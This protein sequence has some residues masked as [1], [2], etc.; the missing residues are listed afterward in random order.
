[1]GDNDSTAYQKLVEFLTSLMSMTHIYQP[2]ML[3]TLLEGGGTATGRQIAAA[4]LRSDLSQLAY[5]EKVA[6]RW[7]ART[8]KKHGL[9][10]H[11]RGLYR[12]TS[13]YSGLAEWERL[14]LIALCEQKLA[15]HVASRQ[16]R[17]LSLRRG[18]A[19][20][21]PGSM[22][23]KAL[24]RASSRC[25]ACGVSNEIRALQVDH[26]VPKRVGGSNEISN[27]QVLC[28]QCNA[29]KRDRDATDFRAVKESYSSREAGCPF[30]EVE[31]RRVELDNTLAIVIKDQFPVTVG[32]SLIV[33]RRHTTHFFDL[34][35]PKVNAVWQLL[36][37]AKGGIESSDSS[38]T[39]FNVGV[40]DGSVAGQTVPHCHVHLI[41]RRKNDVPD[42]GGGVR[43]VIPERQK[44]Q[45]ASAPS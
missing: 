3:R 34:Y 30:C 18:V 12:L 27:L 33:P 11:N 24:A 16:K 1:M 39:G 23:F 4:F 37:E 42:P 31:T 40:N 26:I 44:V 2:V 15:E 29:E 28:Y 32:H 14:A 21:V 13:E 35:Q 19:D 8:L 36:K 38:V 22:R 9:I 17:L 20:P 25:E 7:P 10:E 45:I 43:G 41:P 5:Y 6:A